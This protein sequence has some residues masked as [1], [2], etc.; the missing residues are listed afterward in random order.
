VSRYP[1]RASLLVL[2]L[3]VAAPLLTGCSETTAAEGAAKPTAAS[4]CPKTWR[5][6]WQDLA[7][8]IQAPVYCPTWLPSP[9][10]ARIGRDWNRMSAVSREGLSLAESVAKDRSYLLSILWYG[11]TTAEVHVVMRG[12]P[13]STRIP[14]CTNTTTVNGQAQNAQVPCFQDRQGVRQVGRFRV[15]V[16]TRNRGADAWHVLYAFHHDG[17]LYTVSQHVTPPTTYPQ[18]VRNLNRI[19]RG[20]VLVEPHTQ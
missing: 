16:Y 18:A 3:A 14:R 19:L 8:R 5:A 20:L 2:L 15:T 12:Y 6:G 4:S 1:L 11:G 9:L 17:S 7:N 13:G 10:T